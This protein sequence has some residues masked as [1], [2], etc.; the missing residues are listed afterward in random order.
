L[1]LG[2]IIVLV[3]AVPVLFNFGK[4]LIYTLALSKW[5]TVLFLL[6]FAFFYIIQP[7]FLEGVDFYIVPFFTVVGYLAFLLF[8]LSF[9][10]KSVLTSIGCAFIL[11]LLS[12]SILP[13]PIGLIYEPFFIYSLALTVLSVI[14]CYGKRS[15]LFNCA[16]S[17]LVFNTVIVIRGEY[18]ML[19]PPEAFSA[20]C[21]S[22]LLSY[23]PVSLIAQ[24]RV[25]GFKKARIFQTEASESFLITK[26]KIKKQK[27]K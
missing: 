11:Y 10:V 24:N 18:N 1:P 23:Y 6:S 7:L 19:F 22:T 12:L 20:I 21:L 15:L 16:F 14:L 17:M 2:V 8:K 4:G 5:K 27:K 9:P 13:Q 25:T 3:L 26:N